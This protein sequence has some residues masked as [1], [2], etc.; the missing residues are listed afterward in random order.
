MRTF[1]IALG[2][3]L[4]LLIA[5]APA[6]ASLSIREA[7]RG[8]LGVQIAAGDEGVEILSVVPGTAADRA[9]LEAGDRV[10]E[11]D[12]HAIG[13]FEALGEALSKRTAGERVEIKVERAGKARVT[14]AT[15]GTRGAPVDR[16]EP[17]P[18]PGTVLP[19]PMST[20]PGAP[21]GP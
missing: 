3:A 15:L 5:A 7:E 4:S 18:K 10:L 13:S 21:P 11:I 2:T 6:S 17:T 16:V 12:G 1:A 9:G 20:R 14:T 8:Y 19:P